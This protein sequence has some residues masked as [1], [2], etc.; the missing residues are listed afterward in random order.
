[1]FRQQIDILLVRPH[2]NIPLQVAPLGLGYLASSLM[3]N[4]IAVD[5]KDCLVEN[6]SIDEIVAFIYRKSIKIIGISCCTNEVAWAKR[7]TNKIKSSLAVKIILG[8]LHVSGVMEK[9]YTDI[10]NIDFSIYSE[11]EYALPLLV[12]AILRNDITVKTLQNIPN[13]IWKNNNKIVKNFFELPENLDDIDFPARELI[14]PKKYSRKTPHGF[15]YK[16]SPFASIIATRGCPYNCSFCST[17]I[18]HGKR[19]RKRSPDNI[20]TEIKYLHKKYGVKEIFIE[21][22]NFTF[23]PKFVKDL[24]NKIIETNLNI[25]FSLPNGICI[26]TINEEV[27]RIMRKANFYSFG[28]GIESGSPRILKKMGKMADL[29]MIESKIAMAKRY[30]FY[31]TGFFIIGYPGE[32]I[33]DINATIQFAK[34]LKIDKAAF[35]KYIPLPGTESYKNLIHNGELNQWQPFE[36][37]SARD[38]PY[39]P[40]GIS[41]DELRKYIRKAVKSFYFRPSIILRHIFR[42]NCLLNIKTLAN[43][44][45]RFLI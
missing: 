14:N 35:S 36:G 15:M 6:I 28:V 32:T 3:K 12:K 1:M 10:E 22:D 9:I 13:L 5:I 29:D 25:F 4:Q 18:V 16:G 27:L 21:D 41:K 40:K 42:L 37:L 26:D 34:Q 19:L 20:I 31:I 2:S 45:K 8:G 23:D 30:G 11:G 33:D 17:S 38:I 39:S 24:C 44:V 43:I 7:F